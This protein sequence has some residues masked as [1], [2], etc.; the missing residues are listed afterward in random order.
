[1]NDWNETYSVIIVEDDLD[2]VWLIQSMIEDTAGLRF[3]GYAS[4][5][6]GAG[7]LAAETRADIALVDLGLGSQ[8]LGGIEA[9][10]AIRLN[11]RAKVL[12]LTSY[13]D[14]E[15]IIS[16]SKRSFA[17]GYIFKSQYGQLTDIIRKTARGNTPQ[18]VMIKELI[19]KDLTNAE[20]S[21][22][23]TLMGENVAVHSAEKTSANQKT[24]IFKKLG[25]KNAQELCR[26]F[27]NY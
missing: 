20:R 15:I 8:D 19:L 17:S 7:R 13:E 26:I 11:S 9:A 23:S 6:A 10:K 3:A 21:V 22:F 4:D 1:M 12:L 18:Q 24:S 16:A 5:I 2:F 27:H 25:L 14:P